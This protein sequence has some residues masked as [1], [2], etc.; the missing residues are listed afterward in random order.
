MNYYVLV[1]HL[2]EDYMSRRALY[3]DAHLQLVREAHRRG[4]LL[5]AGAL[6]D[7]ADRA[8][9]VFRTRDRSIPENFARNDPY[10]TNGLVTKWEVRPWTV[11]IGHERLDAP[12][13]G[14]GR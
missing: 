14:G 4:E 1:Y 5:L 9:L 13:A 2:V 7:P 6:A 10:V 8:L 12:Q 3:R 11:V